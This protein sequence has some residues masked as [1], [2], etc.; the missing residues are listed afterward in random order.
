MVADNQ[1]GTYDLE[2]RDWELLKDV[3]RVLAPFKFCQKQLEG[4]KYVTCSRILPAINICRNELSRHS[5]SEE[6]CV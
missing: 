4:D 1:V 2:Q 3:M 6:D 5:V